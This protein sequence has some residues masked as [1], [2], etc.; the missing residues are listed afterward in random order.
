MRRALFL[1]RDGVINKP[2]LRN[3]KTYPP[4]NLDSFE[5]I[6]NIHKLVGHAKT[7]GYY[8][9]VVTNQPDIARKKTNISTVNAMHNHI[10]ENL[11]VDKIYLC[12]HD[13]ADQCQCRKPAPGML[14]TAASEFDITLE[15]SILIGDRWKDIDAAKRAGCDSIFVDYGLAEDLKA[16]PTHRITDILEAIN[17]LNNLENS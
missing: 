9:F 16:Q 1:D 2:I 4:E 11:K 13:D 5:F 7:L 6:E 15:K 17:I 10:M 12:P 3:G 8:V 14:M